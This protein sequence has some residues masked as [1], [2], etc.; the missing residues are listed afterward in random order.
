[1]NNV[2]SKHK[3]KLYASHELEWLDLRVTKDCLSRALRIMAA[4]IHM[5]DQEGFKV[6]VEKKATE[7]TSV[8]VYG[9]KIRFGLIEGFK[10]IKPTPKPTG[11]AYSYNPVTLESTGILSIEVWNYYSGGPQK[12]WR[13][14]EGAKLEEQLPSCVAGMMQIALK[15]RAEEKARYEEKLAEQKKVEEVEAELKK[16]SEGREENQSS[17]TGRRRV[18]PSR[19]TSEVYHGGTSE[20]IEGHRVD[21]VGGAPSRLSRSPERNP[22]VDSGRQRRSPKAPS[23]CSLGMV[24][25]RRML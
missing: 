21:S 2:P 1:M 4:L 13:D 24:I 9:E 12:V 19:A 18:A 16:N 7:S 5:L 17:P 8:V 3:E 25:A 22:K 10:Q 15:E 11:S 20:F 6:A 14:R 23:F